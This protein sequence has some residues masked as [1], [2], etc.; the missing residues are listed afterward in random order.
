MEEIKNILKNIKTNGII[1]K[2]DELGRIVIP[3]DYRKSKVE[4]GKTKVNVFNI[5]EYVII[6]IL[7]NQLEK[8]TRKFDELG[9]VVI[10]IEIRDLLGWQQ[11]DEIEIWN[12]GKYFILKRVVLKCVFC[13][14]DKKKLIYYRDKLVCEKC[15]KALI[16]E[17]IKR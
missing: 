13:D 16:E 15:I 8:T 5:G 9:R 2:L 3:I 1:R 4:D 7:D 11:K 14:Y 12:F 10:N 17:Y 6:E